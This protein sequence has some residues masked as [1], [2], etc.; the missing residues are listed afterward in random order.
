M[1]YKVPL[2]IVSKKSGIT[3]ESGKNIIYNYDE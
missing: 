2:L 1:M 3:A